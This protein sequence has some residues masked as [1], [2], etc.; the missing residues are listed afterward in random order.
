MHNFLIL[1]RKCV[2][3]TIDED[4]MKYTYNSFTLA[5]SNT[6]T[7]IFSWTSALLPHNKST[8]STTLAVPI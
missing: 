4:C 3:I 1:S 8:L 7:F 2:L 6:L 5:Q